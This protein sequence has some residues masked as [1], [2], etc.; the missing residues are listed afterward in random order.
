M[1]VAQQRRKFRLPIPNRFV[2][3]FDAAEKEHLRQIAQTQFVTESPEHN[4]RDDIGRILG[5]IQ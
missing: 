2:G 4:Q 5:A 3:E 1:I